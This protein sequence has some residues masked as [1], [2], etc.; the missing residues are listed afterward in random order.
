MH[1]ITYRWN[2]IGLTITRLVDDSELELI[3]KFALENRINII[4]IE[5]VGD[6]DGCV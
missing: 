6:Q 5:K 2:S 3:K 1:E 4:L